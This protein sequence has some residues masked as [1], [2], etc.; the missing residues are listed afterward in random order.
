MVI[1]CTDK[2]NETEVAAFLQT[3]GAIEVN[4]QEAES[5]WWFGRYDRPQKLY[6][7]EEV[8]Y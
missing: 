2:T 7:Q 5:G 8:G 6:R 1:E 3:H 4:V